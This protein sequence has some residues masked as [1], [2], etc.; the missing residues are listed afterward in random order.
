MVGKV[1]HISEVLLKF[2]EE[3]KDKINEAFENINQIQNNS[4][5]E[6]IK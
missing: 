5:K 6:I 1:V 3:N 2:A 4:K